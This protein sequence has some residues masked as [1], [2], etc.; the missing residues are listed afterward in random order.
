MDDLTLSCAECSACPRALLHECSPDCHADGCEPYPAEDDCTV[1]DQAAA[2]AQFEDARRDVSA[3]VTCL[4]ADPVNLAGFKVIM[5]N[6]NRS[7]MAHVAVKLL[8][9]VCRITGTDA[10]GFRQ[11]S[12]ADRG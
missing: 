4:L 12:G 6:A 8:S 9:D 5:A 11:W 7:T 10:A 3:A 1:H 2:L